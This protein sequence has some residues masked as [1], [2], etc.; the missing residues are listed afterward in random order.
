MSRLTIA[1][2]PSARRDDAASLAGFGEP[3]S[4]IGRAYP[5]TAM[6]SEGLLA[7]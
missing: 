3:N 4:L 6:P 7:K 5:E 1:P 2:K